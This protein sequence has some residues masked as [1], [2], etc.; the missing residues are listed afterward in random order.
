MQC[1]I[2]H[3]KDKP[4]A[5]NLFPSRSLQG[6]DV[7]VYR[8]DSTMEAS[9]QTEALY[10]QT[11]RTHLHTTIPGKKGNEHDCN[12]H[13]TRSGVVHVLRI[14][15]G[16]TSPKILSVNLNLTCSTPI[17]TPKTRNVVQSLAT[18]LQWSYQRTKTEALAELKQLKNWGAGKTETTGQLSAWWGPSY[19]NKYIYIY[20]YIYM[21][22]C[23]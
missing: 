11:K 17:P 21:C 7:F 4:P 10:K 6:T 3:L 9:R 23:A 20:I 22:H 1:P 2:N 18:I 8:S 14:W 13:I 16:S 12:L 15:R 19:A 5:G